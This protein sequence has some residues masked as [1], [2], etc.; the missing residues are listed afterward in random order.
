MLLA[1]G[2]EELHVA[3]HARDR[4]LER[5][6]QRAELGGGVVAELPSL[7]PAH[8]H[9]TLA[10]VHDALTHSFSM[11]ASSA[12]PAATSPSTRRTSPL[13]AP[14]L[15]AAEEEEEEEG[16]CMIAA[17]SCSSGVRSIDPHAADA[18]GLAPCSST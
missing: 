8:A 11:R 7:R 13:I 12:S 1:L 15:P 10:G 14:C 5:V 18:A 17:S 3:L 4:G 9:V 2:A 6:R 16:A